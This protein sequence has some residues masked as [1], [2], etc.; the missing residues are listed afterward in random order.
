MAT[1]GETPNSPAE[2]EMLPAE[3][4]ML[5][6]RSEAIDEADDD[7]LLTVDEVAVDLGIDLDE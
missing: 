1:D 7:D 3:Q 2:D 6:K 5:C 4:E